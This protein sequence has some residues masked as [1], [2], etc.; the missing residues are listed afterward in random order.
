MQ[1][2]SEFG[3]HPKQMDNLKTQL[4]DGAAKVLRSGG[5]ADGIAGESEADVLY[6]QRQLKGQND[7]GL[8]AAN[9]PSGHCALVRRESNAAGIA[10]VPI[11]G[12]IALSRP[13]AAGGRAKRTCI[14]AGPLHATPMHEDGLWNLDDRCCGPAPLRLPALA[15]QRECL[16]PH[17]HG[18]YS[19]QRD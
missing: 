16:R 8:K 4:L 10:A 7:F 3:V 17:A 15:R 2:A 11:T 18:R 1:L 12:G 5:P 13:I 14:R 19:K 9:E 6:R